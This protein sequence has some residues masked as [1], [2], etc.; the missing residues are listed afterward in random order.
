ME[1]CNALQRVSK[2]KKRN[3]EEKRFK[4]EGSSGGGGDVGGGGL[5]WGEAK[6]GGI[7]RHIAKAQGELKYWGADK[8]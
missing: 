1:L 4:E 3:K 5:G 7:L 2:K 6:W 8:T